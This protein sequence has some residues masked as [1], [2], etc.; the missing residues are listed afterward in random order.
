MKKLEII[1][2]K[3]QK[4]PSL[5]KKKCD[6]RQQYKR[7]RQM[8]YIA[9][10]RKTKCNLIS[11]SV[12]NA[13]YINDFDRQGKHKSIGLFWDIRTNNITAITRNQ[14]RFLNQ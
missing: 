9:K 6:S 12:V 10:S 11:F 3:L 13:E 5:R 4:I 1:K 7:L 8:G 14:K 2:M